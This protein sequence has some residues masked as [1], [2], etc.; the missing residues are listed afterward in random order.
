MAIKTVNQSFEEFISD[1]L[2]GMDLK[3]KVSGLTTEEEYSY[4][5]HSKTLCRY[6]DQVR[7]NSINISYEQYI[8]DLLED[9]E[10]EGLTQE[11]TP[12]ELSAYRVMA[13]DLLQ[14]EH[15]QLNHRISR[16]T[17][18]VMMSFC[19]HCG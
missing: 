12:A 4:I 9:Y 1:K 11:L 8:Q 7:F 19:P 6:Q 14:W 10:I 17:V 3:Q 16:L 5:F 18:P 2:L 13:S 15:L